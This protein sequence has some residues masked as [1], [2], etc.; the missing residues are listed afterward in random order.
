[1]NREDLERELDTWLD[2][3]STEYGTAESR[4]GL[5]ARIIA[6]VNSRLAKRRLHFRWLS[7]AMAATA[8]LIFS[9]YVLL[10]R[11]E[12]HPAGESVMQKQRGSGVPPIAKQEQP[13]LIVQAEPSAKVYAN[14]HVHIKVRE[15]PKGHFLSAKISDQ[16]RYLVSFVKTVSEQ[17][18][19]SEPEAES[20]PLQMPDFEL[21]T[22]QIPKA[23]VSSI[24]IDMVQLPIAHQS[25]DPL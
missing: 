23:Q 20:G 13:P 14:K 21:S 3:A 6:N 11:I 10:T 17:N 1:M 7:L 25:E 12:D 18:F 22:I 24:N 15:T 16:E 4:A 9:C 8:I 2:R 19:A 5:E